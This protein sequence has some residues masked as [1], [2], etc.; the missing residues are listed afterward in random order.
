METNTKPFE[1]LIGDRL[2]AVFR[3]WA[4]TRDPNLHIVV[5]FMN[6]EVYL[7]NMHACMCSVIIG[8]G[9]SK[10]A[11]VVYCASLYL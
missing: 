10:H 6:C 4:K 3:D 9:I 1:G 8:K 5:A 2:I 11:L 7:W